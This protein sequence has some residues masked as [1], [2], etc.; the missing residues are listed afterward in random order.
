MLE[1]RL[2]RLEAAMNV[3]S[4]AGGSGITQ[5]RPI[6]L[7]QSKWTAGEEDRP[8]NSRQETTAADVNQRMNTDEIRP[9][10]AATPPKVPDID[11]I[12]S[13][14]S[15]KVTSTAPQPGTVTPTS[16]ICELPARIIS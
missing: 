4:G 1:D 10:V 14:T 7:S 9:S 16:L 3:M 2:A 5:T 8:N 12:E 15:T 11:S 13:V 6:L